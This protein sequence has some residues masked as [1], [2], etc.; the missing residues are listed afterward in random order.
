MLD[1][2]TNGDRADVAPRT[3]ALAQALR[4]RLE[5]AGAQVNV[6]RSDNEPVAVDERCRQMTRS[7]CELYVGLDLGGGSVAHYYTSTNGSKVARLIVAQQ[8]GYQTSPEATYMVTHSPCTAVVVRA[9]AT[10]DATAAGLFEALRR[11]YTP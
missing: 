4:E 5:A 6:S 7:A 1:P 8:K 11:Y 10:D 2:F 3:L 9:R